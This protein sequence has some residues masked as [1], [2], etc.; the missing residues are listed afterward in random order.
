MARAIVWFKNDLRLHDN[1][2]LER[3]AELVSS[4]KASEVAFFRGTAMQIQAK[5]P[6]N[7]PSYQALFHYPRIAVS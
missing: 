6:Y 2:V 5:A 1:Y 7:V 3:A 4:G